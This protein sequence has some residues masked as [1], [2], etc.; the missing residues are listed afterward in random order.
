MTRQRNDDEHAADGALLDDDLEPVEVP[1]DHLSPEAL[2]GLV[3][4]F[5]TRD[6]TDYGTHEAALARKIGDGL[7]Q[8]ERGE[9]RVV[10]DPA[11]RSANLVHARD[12]ARALAA[13]A[14]S[15]R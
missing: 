7:R 10:F 3:E 1:A 11:S 4:E 9:V 6:G 5:V 8:V 14:K 13:R 12:L 2:Q 15:R